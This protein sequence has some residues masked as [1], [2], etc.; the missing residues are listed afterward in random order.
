LTDGPASDREDDA[1]VG[2][3]GYEQAFERTISKFASFAVA[4]SFI[5]IATGIFTT[6]GYVLQTGGPLGMWTWLLVGVGQLAVALVLATLAARIPLTGSIYQWGTRLA[7]PSVGWV[8]GWLSFAYLSV[9]TVAVDVTLASEVLPAL[10][11]YQSTTLSGQIGTLVIL[12]VQ[13]LLIALSTRITALINSWA[14][15]AELIG[16]ALLAVA[17]L[18]VALVTGDGDASNLF[19]Y[20]AAEK[21]G[22]FSIIPAGAFMLSILLGAFTNTGFESAANLAEETHDPHIVVPRAMWSST[23][24]ATILGSLFLGALTISIDNIPAVTNS[25]TPV[26]DIITDSLGGIGGTFFLVFVAIAQFACGLIIFITG[27]RLTWA[28][29][30]DRRFPGYQLWS[31]VNLTTDT[32][33][34][35]TAFVFVLAIVLLF[36]VNTLPA[37]ISASVLLPGLIYVG[38]LLVHVFT[39]R[40]QAQLD[41]AEDEQQRRERFSLGRWE[42]PVLTLAFAWLA[43]EV[44]VLVGPQ[45]RTAHFY[46]LGMVGVGLVYY[47]YMRI[48]NPELLRHAQG[49]NPGDAE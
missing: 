32:P 45:F 25:A 2:R 26:A 21:A 9:L 36:L 49:A 33:V 34:W 16:G 1:V 28:L 42:I 48:R 40:Q 27:V 18:V 3:Y 4:F 17:L 19:E 43:L 46:V 30:R 44:W 29:S 10:L 6:Y 14:V 11:G 39:R 41:A 31:R 47:G 37:L 38:I 5:S 7:N 20:G 13:A 12:V 24:I 35:A 22:Y 23:L 15:A 8:L